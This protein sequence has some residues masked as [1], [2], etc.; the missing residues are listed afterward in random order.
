MHIWPAD[1]NNTTQTA[2]PP[3]D[4]RYL[5]TAEAMKAGA[6][7]VVGG[8]LIVAHNFDWTPKVPVTL[9]LGESSVTVSTYDHSNIVAALNEYPQFYRGMCLADP[10]LG[11]TAAVALLNLH[12]TQG[13]VGLR[14]NPYM[15]ID[16]DMSV[17]VARALFQRAGELAMP[18]GF[19]CM[20][21]VKVH[22]KHIEQ[23]M[24]ASPGTIVILDHYGFF[25]QPPNPSGTNDEEAWEILLALATKYPQ[26]HIKLSA[27]HRVSTGPWP[28]SDLASRVQALL[29]AYGSKRLLWGSDF[30][31]ILPLAQFDYQRAAKAI[32]SWSKG[33]SSEQLKMS[34]EELTDITFGNAKRLFW[35]T[36]T[37]Q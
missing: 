15:F 13:F 6:G 26:L 29:K 28:F 18:V 27:F 12:Y 19:M 10:S 34:E 9:S 3:E 17:E 16:D 37:P 24:A 21:G 33:D 25:R 35:K 22:L 1:W 11:T 31:Y 36:T 8:A 14:F 32:T 30:P 2:L 5:A 23:L 7:D 20:K 4:I